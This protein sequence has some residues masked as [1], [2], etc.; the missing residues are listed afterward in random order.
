MPRQLRKTQCVE[1]LAVVKEGAAIKDLIGS[2][3]E[4]KAMQREI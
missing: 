1:A 4:D 2:S 3:L